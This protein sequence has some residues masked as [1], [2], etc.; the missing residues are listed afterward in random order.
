MEQERVPVP[1][2]FY[3]H[4]KN[5]LYQ[6]KAVA[7]HSETKEKMVVYQAM[8]GNFE[9]Y[10]RPY[11]MFMSE[12]DHIKY[13]E[14]LQKYRFERVDLSKEPQ[15][16]QE[17]CKTVE[18]CSSGREQE[19]VIQDS[20]TAAEYTESEQHRE[21]TVREQIDPR[22][23]RFLDAETYQ[24][25]LNVITGLRDKLDDWLITAMAISIDAEVEE[26]PL[27]RRYDSL[28][29]CIKAHIR[30]ETERMR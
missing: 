21:E 10:V 26:G 16:A 4:F 13:P 28:R 6:I 7:Y 22:L 25:K 29:S 19:R 23:E 8:Y 9:I 12:V 14:V 3:R 30:Y 5:K 2:E 27:D 11:D 1:G 20:D 15:Q 17:T 18:P 24:D